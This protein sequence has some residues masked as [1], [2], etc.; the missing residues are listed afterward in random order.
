MFFKK[1]NIKIC[2]G[3]TRTVL[4][5]GRK[6]IKFPR[7]KLRG[8]ARWEC[9]LEGILANC[10]EADFG[11]KDFDQLCPVLFKFPG[12]LFIVMERA[13]PLP[14]R[15]WHV[16]DVDD[17]MLGGVCPKGVRSID[18]HC[19]LSPDLV[20]NKRSSFGLLSNRIVVV[21]YG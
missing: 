6:A 9:F 14:E 16:L 10:Q 11:T 20:E 12:G 19:G 17:F 1:L 8:H 18:G 15:L 13:Q 4:L 3:S 21:D 7:I 2:K 5:I